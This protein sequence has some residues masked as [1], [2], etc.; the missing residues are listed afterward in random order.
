ME[1]LAQEYGCAN[2]WTASTGV[3]ATA[4]LKMVRAYRSVADQSHA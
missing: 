3:L 2:S 4:L 1:R